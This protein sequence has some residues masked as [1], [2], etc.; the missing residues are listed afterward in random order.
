MEDQRKV[1]IKPKSVPSGSFVSKEKIIGEIQEDKIREMERAQDDAKQAAVDEAEKQRLEAIEALLPKTVGASFGEVP[2]AVFKDRFKTV[3]SQVTEKIHLAHGCCTYAFEPAPNLPITL[4]TM[5]NREM[6][7]LR[8]FTPATDPGDDAA[9]YMEEDTLFRNVRFIIGVTHFDGTELPALPIPKNHV[10][11]ADVT[12]KWLEDPH[13]SK[14]LD[15]AEDLP[16]ELMD[17]VGGA[18]LDLTMAYRY[19]L[20][21]NLKNQFA[22]PSPT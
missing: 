10:L 20:Q 7:F 1:V 15:W 6:K 14:R 21:E 16:E 2:Y 19:A 12:S 9:K 11:D 5:K 22:P 3:W 17:V 18:F 13:V 8:R 4:R